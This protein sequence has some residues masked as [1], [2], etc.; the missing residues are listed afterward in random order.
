MPSFVIARPASRPMQF[1][2]ASCL[3]VQKMMIINNAVWKPGDMVYVAGHY[4][5]LD[6]QITCRSGLILWIFLHDH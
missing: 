1:Q 5:K 4:D 6:N 3:R 2:Q